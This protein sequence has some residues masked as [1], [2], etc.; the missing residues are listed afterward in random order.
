[1]NDKSRSTSRHST[2]GKVEEE[3]LRERAELFT[4]I[5][6]KVPFGI[7]LAAFPEG[8][9]LEVN[10]G[11]ERITGFTREEALGKTSVELT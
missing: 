7:T 2:D 11:W 10:E 9:Y 1:M 5:H 6:D 4:A 8:A 3:A